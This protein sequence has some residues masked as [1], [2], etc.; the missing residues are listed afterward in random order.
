[1]REARK[2][3]LLVLMFLVMGFAV[4]SQGGLVDPTRQTHIPDIEWVV[5]P[6]RNAE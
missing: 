4:M 6:E 5:E 2:I 3:L 1:M